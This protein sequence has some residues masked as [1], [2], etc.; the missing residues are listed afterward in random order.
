LVVLIFSSVAENGKILK[1]TE[2]FGSFFGK[3]RCRSL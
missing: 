3:G 1:E 2:N